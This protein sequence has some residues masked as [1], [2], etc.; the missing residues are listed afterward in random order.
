[1]RFRPAF[2]AGLFLC[3]LVSFSLFHGKV[4]ALTPHTI[5]L[6]LF[7]SSTFQGTGTAGGAYI[8]FE[9]NAW[10][11]ESGGATFYDN[12]G[13][14]GTAGSNNPAFLGWLGTDTT[15]APIT[16]NWNNQT[17]GSALYM[18]DQININTLN[19]PI[20]IGFAGSTR[21][22]V[23]LG[24]TLN[25]T[26]SGAILGEPG[27]GD[28]RTGAPNPTNINDPNY[29]VRWDVFEITY[30]GGTVATDQM[31]LTAIN[32]TAIPM[33]LS[34]SG[35]LVGGDGTVVSNLQGSQ[36]VGNTSASNDFAA[37]LASLQNLANS[38]TANNSSGWGSLPT[39]WYVEG[40]NTGGTTSPGSEFLRV[41]GPNAGANI[42][43][44]SATSSETVSGSINQ[45]TTI[46]SP[47]MNGGDLGLA[48][49]AVIGPSPTFVPYIQYVHDNSITTLITD[50]INN[51][52]YQG[53]LS[54]MDWTT[55]TYV[56]SATITTSATSQE[57]YTGT[58]F[59]QAGPA[60]VST[61]TIYNGSDFTTGIAGVL[62]II[63]PEAASV[64]N[65]IDS[66][67]NNLQSKTIYDGNFNSYGPIFIWED[68]TGTAITTNTFMDF[69][70]INGLLGG[71]L[72]GIQNQISH[73]ITSGFTYGFIGSTY[74]PG[75]TYGTQT[76]NDI[77]S[78]GWRE[79]A[80]SGTYSTLFAELWS[81]TA[82]FFHQW[83][84]IVYNSSTSIYGF[85]YSDFFQ[86]VLLNNTQA[87][88]NGGTYNITSIDLTILGDV[89]P[90]P[91]TASLVLLAGG[92]AYLLRKKFRSSR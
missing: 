34:T 85:T 44:T 45:S 75:G 32:M 82:T 40:S 20:T 15:A 53:Q 10:L 30:Q 84:E 55:T 11:Y 72:N 28:Y 21:L 31:N 35:T 66:Y 54:T 68:H 24:A 49:Q 33:Q 9:T 46:L 26:G 37:L 22:Y 61:S 8:Y 16:M 80:Q 63:I 14:H 91:A 38:N 50:T 52:A 17:G 48:S 6:N 56:A 36:T 41:I 13:A 77:G 83:A 23:S 5:E 81:N 78:P 92:M 4:S 19:S 47:I 29:N 67:A 43:T 57:V 70:V 90:E 51:R 71:D 7:N 73:D 18:S 79:L 76:I 60:L 69:N 62:T 58:M 27:T 87:V 25:I 64:S 59:Y 86:P 1:M 65:G 2:P 88:V 39:N 89:V 74:Q 42:G 12:T 3:L